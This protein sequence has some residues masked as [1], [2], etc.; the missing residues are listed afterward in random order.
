MT[1]ELPHA[2]EAAFKAA[3]RGEPLVLGNGGSAYSKAIERMLHT[4]VPM[5][6][7]AAQKRRLSI[8]SRSAAPKPA[9]SRSAGGLLGALRRKRAS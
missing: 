9:E 8:V 2:G 3:S 1:F 4:L 5:E 7:N 6:A